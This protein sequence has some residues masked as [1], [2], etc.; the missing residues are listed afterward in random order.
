MKRFL[1]VL[2]ILALVGAAAAIAAAQIPAGKEVLTFEHKLGNVTFEHA[3]HAGLEGV[4]CVT[5]HHKTEGDAT[6]QA[7]VECHPSKVEKD[8]DDIKLKDAVHD[9]CWGCHQEKVDAGLKGG[10]VKGAKS[11]KE[12]HIKG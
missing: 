3:T 5:C 7:C 9:M 6:P 8:S 4:E 2:A 1:I 12:C 11:C 10:P